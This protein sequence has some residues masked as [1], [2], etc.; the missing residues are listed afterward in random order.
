MTTT[1]GI[2]SPYA[3]FLDSDFDSDSDSESEGFYP[4]RDE[5]ETL[6]DYLARVMYFGFEAHGLEIKSLREEMTEGFESVDERFQE[7]RAEISVMKCDISI[8][9]QD[10]S[11]LKKDVSI[12]KKD[13]AL[14][15]EDITSIKGILV[16]MQ[17]SLE[18]L[19]RDVALIRQ[20]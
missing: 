12:L 16:S 17:I 7:V 10:V 3:D 19:C 13:V 8:L 1:N 9:K 6:V 5:H 15:K 2:P 4:E 11:V 14:L 18:T 20:H